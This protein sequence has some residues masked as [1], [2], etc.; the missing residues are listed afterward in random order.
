MKEGEQ[1]RRR[2]SLEKG[3]LLYFEM[4]H[5]QPACAFFNPYAAR[6]RVVRR[7]IRNLLVGC[8]SSALG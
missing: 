6:E 2:E 4:E 3:P 1:Q 8:S 7:S 5:Q